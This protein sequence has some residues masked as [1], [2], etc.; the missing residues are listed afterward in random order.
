M[1]NSYDFSEQNSWNGISSEKKNFLA[2]EDHGQ[3]ILSVLQSFREQNIFYDFNIVVKEEIIPCHRCVLAAC[4]DFFRAM[5]EVKMKERDD[6]CVTIT[7]LS[8]KA[9]KAFLDYAYTGKARITDDNVEMFFQLSSFLQVPFLSKACS[10]FLIKSISLVNCLHLLSLS[11]N[12]GSTHLFNQV[13]CF[14]QHHFHL[15]FKSRE[16]LEMNFGVLQ[17]CL[18]SDELNVPEE[19]MVL[20]VVITWIKYNLESRR[21]HLPHLITKVRLHQ[22]SEDTLQDYLL[23][24]ECLLKS[25]NCFDIIVD[26]IKCVQVSSGLFT[27]ARPSTTEK[28]IF[29]HKT[30]ENGEN[31]HTF[32]YNIKSDSWKILPQSHLIDLPGSSLSSYGEKIFLMGGCK[33][34]CCRKIR[35]H[36]AESYHDATDQTWCYCPVKNEFFLVSTMKTPRTMH[37]SVM[38]VSRLFVIGGKTRGSRDIKS[39]LDVESFDPLSKEWISVSPLPRGIYYPEASACQNVIYVLGSEVEIADAFNPSLDCFFKYNATTDQWSELVAEFGQFFHA[40]L[41]KAVSVNCTL[42]ICDLSTYKVYSFCPDTCVWKGEGSFECAGFNA[43][44]IGIEDKIYI[45]GGDYAPDEITDEVQ[46]YHSSKSEW[47]EVSPMPRALTEFYCQVIQ[48]NKYRD[49][50]FSNHF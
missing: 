48:F 36:I 22:L 1:A 2:S 35:L 50:W 40:T 11:D 24:E 13:L 7:N 46:V 30:E 16:F 17:K 23:N 42:Y 38:A 37:T 10:D 29:I 34:K 20:K 19:G 49:P 45:L 6:G 47:E 3:K 28:Y 8:S 14:V 21:K 32:C 27:D 18:E 33:G 44:A 5:F 43:G 39:L 31:Q 9:I 26:A 4:S 15:L 12:Y 41:I 25:T